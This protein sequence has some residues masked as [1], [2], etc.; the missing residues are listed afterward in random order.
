MPKLVHPAG[1][2]I[3][4]KLFGF[5]QV[6]L[7]QNAQ[8]T[9]IVTY[10]FGTF[11]QEARE[12]PITRLVVEDRRILLDVEDE[13][14]YA[15]AVYLKLVEELKVLSGSIAI[16]Y[17][18]PKVKAQ[19]SE[20]VTHLNFP[21][22]RLISSQLYD[23]I[24]NTLQP[25]TTSDIATSAINFGQ[26]VLI[27]QFKSLD[28]A[29]EKSSITLNPKE[30]IIAPRPGIPVEEQIYITKAPI[31]TERHKELLIALENALRQEVA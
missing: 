3:L 11:H 14:I 28:S 22:D 30:F 18:A 21:A 15:D 2:Q 27:V 19:E 4:Q 6:S 29:L 17:L 10:Q 31:D 16:D 8:G 23:F 9:P 13:M 20:I 26:I 24:N 1:T 7:S 25:M 5:S 12:I